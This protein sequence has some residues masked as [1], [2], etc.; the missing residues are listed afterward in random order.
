MSYPHTIRLHGPWQSAATQPS[1][2]AASVSETLTTWTRRFGRP[3]NLEPS[4]RVWLVVQRPRASLRVALNRVDLG[5]IPAGCPEWR[6]AVTNLLEP[7]N[8][9]V[10]AGEPESFSGQGGPGA[11]VA[12]GRKNAAQGGPAGARHVGLEIDRGARLDRFWCAA[13][14]SSDGPSDESEAQSGLAGGQLR[15]GATINAPPRDQPW[16]I[17]VRLGATE[18]AYAELPAGSLWRAEL[19]LPALPTWLPTAPGCKPNLLATVEVRLLDGGQLAFRV[20]R[21]LGL[22]CVQFLPDGNQIV[23]PPV[24]IHAPLPLWPGREPLGDET[25]Q[26]RALVLAEV[27]PES[28]YDGFDRQGTL[29]VQ[30]LSSDEAATLGPTLAH[31]PSIVAWSATA[32]DWDEARKR[33]ARVCDDGRPWLAAERWSR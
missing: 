3:Q 23:V 18:L 8:E 32:A 16:A 13:V 1:P 27:E 31:H 25:P 21:K 30:R 9:L 19:A 5:T 4:E 28:L 10:L 24:A 14:A 7:R 12:S 6:T 15:L 11:D 2:A 20:E 22:R 29:I 17:V 26:A 33:F